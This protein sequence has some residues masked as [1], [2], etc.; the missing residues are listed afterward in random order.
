[1]DNSI[2]LHFIKFCFIINGLQA[3]SFYKF[4]IET[5]KLNHPR[6][7]AVAVAMEKKFDNYHALKGEFGAFVSSLHDFLFPIFLFLNFVRKSISL[8]YTYSV[9]ISNE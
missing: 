1:M 8:R 7:V 9:S 5:I 3:L 2:C 6:N 4:D